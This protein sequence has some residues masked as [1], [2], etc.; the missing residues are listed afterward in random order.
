VHGGATDPDAE[1]A[2][3]PRELVE[4]EE[5]PR[6]DGDVRVTVLVTPLP[7]LMREV[8]LAQRASAA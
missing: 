6:G 4:G 5:A 2:A 1:Q 3:A 8:A 7:I